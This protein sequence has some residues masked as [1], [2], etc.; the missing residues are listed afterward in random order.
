M[1]ILELRGRPSLRGG[2]GGG[3]VSDRSDREDV[4]A[5]GEGWWGGVSLSSPCSAFDPCA[6]TGL[7]GALRVPQ[8]PPNPPPPPDKL[9]LSGA[10]ALVQLVQTSLLNRLHY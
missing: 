5:A 8:T 4:M 2:T 1:Q 6:Q 3:F 10:E 9:W 7:W